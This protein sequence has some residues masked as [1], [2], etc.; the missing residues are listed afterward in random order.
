[1]ENDLGQGSAL[2]DAACEACSKGLPFTLP[3]DATAS[4]SISTSSHPLEPPPVEVVTVPEP[5]GRESRRG[6]FTY[7]R[8]PA[9]ER[10]SEQEGIR[11]QR[12]KEVEVA[13][14]RPGAGAQPHSLGA[15]WAK[16]SLGLG[17]FME[18]NFLLF[19]Y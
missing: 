8:F 3:I 16:P 11:S 9:Q 7:D 6:R 17:F 5:G 15:R 10:S 19:G 13:L 2:F 1:M 12:L 18:A 4:T 14:K